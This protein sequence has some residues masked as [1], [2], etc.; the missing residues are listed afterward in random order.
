MA[1]VVYLVRPLLYII[2]SSLIVAY[3]MHPLVDFLERKR[4][5]RAA[6]A[7]VA[8][9]I[10]FASLTVFFIYIVPVLVDEL[11]SL[12]ANLPGYATTVYAEVERIFKTY[13][14]V[15]L[16]HTLSER[17]NM[18]LE[19]LRQ[20]GISSLMPVGSVAGT[21]F[22]SVF[23]FLSELLKMILMPVFIFF[24]LRDFE[25]MKRWI[26]GYI[27]EAHR[28]TAGKYNRIIDDILKHY[29]AGQLI[30]CF[31]LAFI[32]SVGLSIIGVNFGI[33]VGIMT[34]F[35]FIVPYVGAATGF[36][37]SM[38]I[39][40]FEFGFDKH[41]VYIIVLFAT[42]SI[43]EPLFITPKI[44]GSRLGLH[45]VVVIIALLSGAATFGILGLL[46]AVPFTAILKT[47]LEELKK[48]LREE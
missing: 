20:S 30:I 40:V 5:P 46:V 18:F 37:V 47:L 32:Y 39:G 25:K 33:L 14:G 6:S 27:P 16:P 9:L 29:F 24:F 35:L 22:R 21:I 28:G 38:M 34:G 13:L 41:L 17:K 31:I 4:I 43:V 26:L 23:G 2:I 1:L 36:A 42:V 8:I 45:P 12:F 3:V 19:N 10:F 7:F 11:G 48:S 44:I 15:K